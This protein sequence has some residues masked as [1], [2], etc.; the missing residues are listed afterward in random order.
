MI[1]NKK[2]RDV[3]RL[4][5]RRVVSATNRISFNIINNNELPQSVHNFP[6]HG[7]CSYFSCENEYSTK[8]L[9]S[10]MSECVLLSSSYFLPFL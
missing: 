6:K 3:F 1:N 4:T 7:V 5:E 9:G 10:R 2:P 8:Y